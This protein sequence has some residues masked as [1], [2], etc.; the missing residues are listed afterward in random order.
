MHMKNILFLYFVLSHV[1]GASDKLH[2]G[3]KWDIRKCTKEYIR[4]DL[5][6]IR[7]LAHIG[8]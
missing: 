8:I 7:L 3:L 6:T 5:L 1:L 4:T 2:Y